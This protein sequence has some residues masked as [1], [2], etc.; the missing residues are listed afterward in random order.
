MKISIVTVCYN[1]SLTILD[2][3][4]SVKNQNFKDYEYIVV[5]GGSKDKTLQ[6]LKSYSNIID[7]LVSEEDNGIY[8]AMNKGIS[9]CTGDIIGILNSDD[10]YANS[11]VLVNVAKAFNKFKEIDVVYGNIFYVESKNL[12]KVVRKWISKDYYSD[13]FDNGNVPPHP[14]VF[15]KRNIYKKFGKFNL[16]YSLAADYEFLLRIFKKNKVSSKYL[17]I[18]MIKMRL[19]GAT[20]KTFKNIVKGNFEIFNAWKENGFNFPIKLFFLRIYKRLIQFI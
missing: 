7:I 14:S 20:N 5:D 12:D 4:E 1:S 13:F 16:K 9:L 18:F 3:L 11:N 15:I 19:G 2:T 10:V 8:D 6:I 17:N